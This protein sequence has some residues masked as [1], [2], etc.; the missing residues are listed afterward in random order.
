MRARP[1]LL[2]ILVLLLLAKIIVAAVDIG[3]RVGEGTATVTHLQDEHILHRH[4]V[5]GSE[6]LATALDAIHPLTFTGDELCF[7]K[8]ESHGSEFRLCVAHRRVVDDIGQLTPRC[9]GRVDFQVDDASRLHDVAC[10]R[11]LLEHGVGRQGLHVVGIAHHYREMQLVEE[12]FRIV[13]SLL[14][15]IRHLHGLSVTGIQVETVSQAQGEKNDDD[16]HR[17]DIAPEIQTQKLLEKTIFHFLTVDKK[18]AP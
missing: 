14:H 12:V 3:Y 13:E 16:D 9:A 5:A 18:A 4:L 7:A 1:H 6:L 10:R 2:L 15:H 17:Q 11:R 8:A